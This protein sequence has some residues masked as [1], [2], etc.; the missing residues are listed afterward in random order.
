MEHARSAFWMQKFVNNKPNYLKNMIAVKIAFWTQ[1]TI[2]TEKVWNL[3]LCK[4]SMHQRRHPSNKVKGGQVK[5]TYN[6]Q[7]Y[8]EFRNSPWCQCHI[9][10]N[11][12]ALTISISKS[13]GLGTN[14]VLS[15]CTLSVSTR[16]FTTISIR[17]I[18]LHI[19]GTLAG[20]KRYPLK[21]IS[22]E[23]Y[24]VSCM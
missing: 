9:I 21:T 11:W 15:T 17:S 19:L 18:L 13:Q 16:Y 1:Q 7:I 20:S 22:T 14:Q 2:C 4:Q 23:R 6:L 12:I 8:V 24:R 5:N 3:T 10:K